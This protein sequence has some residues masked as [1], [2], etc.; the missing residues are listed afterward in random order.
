[1]T[2]LGTTKFVDGSKHCSDCGI[3]FWEKDLR[4]GKCIDCIVKHYENE[5]KNITELEYD[6][7]TKGSFQKS[8]FEK[9]RNK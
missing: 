6:R 4:K 7:E 1:M 3:L 2:N 5:L 8:L 9:E